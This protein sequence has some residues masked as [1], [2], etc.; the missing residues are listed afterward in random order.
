M[1]IVRVLLD[2]FAPV[3]RST[4]V[5]SPSKAPTS[6]ARAHILR[7]LRRGDMTTIAHIVDTDRDYVKQ[8]MRY[9]P[10]ANSVLARRIWKVADQIIKDRNRLK[11]LG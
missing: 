1:D 11:N 7:N 8:V 4:N 9:R 6:V 3:M 10:R 5:A 2:I